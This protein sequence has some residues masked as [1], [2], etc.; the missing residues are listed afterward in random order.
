[1]PMM[2]VM[3]ATI[4]LISSPEDAYYKVVVVGLSCTTGTHVKSVLAIPNLVPVFAEMTE[5]C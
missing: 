3:T 2:L 4:C 1:M 5:C